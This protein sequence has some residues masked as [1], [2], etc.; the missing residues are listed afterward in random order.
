MSKRAFLWCVLLFSGLLLGTQAR[1]V[2]VQYEATDLPD[3]VAGQDRWS[4]HYEISGSFGAFE[5]VNLLYAADGY[6]DLDL[7]VAPDP[8]LWSS[9]ITPPDP[10]FT[11]DGLLGLTAL[12]ATSPHKLP[13]TLEFTWLGSGNPGV[14]GFE[15]F[16]DSFNI[17]ASGR[18]R[19]PSAA[20]V[21]E[22]GSLLLLAGA[23]AL[24][25]QRR[26]RC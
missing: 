21:P 7:T 25:V 12:A 2:T 14:Q 26:R 24:L 22:P 6:A 18:T 17:T 4:Y 1:A 9:L 15:V 16:D 11:A 5:G 20:G 23:L 3:L 13:F 10:A 19:P 8:A